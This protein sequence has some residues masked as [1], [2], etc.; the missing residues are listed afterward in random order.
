MIRKIKENDYNQV[1]DLFCN[2]LEN[3]KEYISHGEIQ[4]NIAFDN[5]TLNPNFRKIWK[6]YLLDKITNNSNILVYD[7]DNN[8][9][10]FIISEIDKDL[11]KEFGVICDILVISDKRKS[12]I[13]TLLVNES[14]N[15]FKSKNI[16]QVFF[17]SGLENN[18]SHNFFRKFGF[19]AVSKVFLL[20]IN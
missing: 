20:N 14:I 7:N 12:G 4:M 1:V 10:G 19:K 8:I 5:T 2:N 17:E 16:N 13:G 9:L 3:N 11:G 6:N 15:Y 18:L